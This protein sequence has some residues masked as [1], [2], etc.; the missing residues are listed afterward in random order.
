MVAIPFSVYS[1]TF[2]IGSI[3]KFKSPKILNSPDAHCFILVGIC[4]EAK[5]YIFHVFTSKL[6]KKIAFIKQRKLDY[7]TLVPVKPDGKNRM[8]HQDNCVNCNDPLP[9]T[10]NELEGIYNSTGIE[11]W[12]QIEDSHLEQVYIGTHKSPMVDGWIKDI[13]PKTI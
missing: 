10:I 8:W 2:S 5:N 13:V 7:S 3:H 9:H 6:E 4:P 12:G 1:S 11:P